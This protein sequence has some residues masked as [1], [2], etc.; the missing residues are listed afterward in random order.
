MTHQIELDV[1]N[2]VATIRL[3]RPPLNVLSAAMQREIIRLA[4]EVDERD[5]IRAVVFSGGERAFAAGA[6]IKEMAAMDFA[7]ID[8]QSRVLQEFTH[9]VARIGKPTVAVLNGYVLGGGCELALATDFRFAADDVK[10][11]LPEVQLGIIPG[12]GGTQRLSRLIG[13]SRAKEIIFSGRRV[14]AQEALAIGL[15]NRVYAPGEVYQQAQQWA[16]QF[17]EGPALALRAA[18]Q[19]IDAGLEV[20]LATGLQIECLAFTSLFAT[21][22][23]RLGMQTFIEEGPGRARFAGR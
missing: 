18:K 12:A 1:D 9:A 10:I 6:D 15:V 19:A 5:D 22:D 14:E 2:A 20:D 23:Q 13:S 7:A 11:G 17:A 3:N 8:R 16:A 4:R 21:D